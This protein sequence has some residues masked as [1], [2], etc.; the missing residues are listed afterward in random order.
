M[1]NFVILFSI[2][3]LPQITTLKATELNFIKLL[4]KLKHHEKCPAQ[5][6]GFHVQGQYHIPRVRCILMS[7]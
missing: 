4:L 6:L 7:L 2:L 5:H 3:Y 1:F